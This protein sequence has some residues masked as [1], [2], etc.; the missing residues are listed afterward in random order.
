MAPEQNLSSCARMG[1]ET[2]Y[3]RSFSSAQTTMS[4]LPVTYSC[5][6]WSTRVSMNDLKSG[7]RRCFSA[8]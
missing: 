2:A 3:M 8:S 1:E 4:F 7:W 6:Q 5:G